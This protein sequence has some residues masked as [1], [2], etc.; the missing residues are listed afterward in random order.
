[1]PAD[2]VQWMVH[3]LRAER[4]YT[5]RVLAFDQ[6]GR[7]GPSK[8]E[9]VARGRTAEQA[10]VVAPEIIYVLVKEA[11]IDGYA[12]LLDWRAVALSNIGIGANVSQQK[13][14]TANGKVERESQRGYKVRKRL[15]INDSGKIKCEISETNFLKFICRKISEIFK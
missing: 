10:P 6:Y 13:Y 15:G 11:G 9:N 12:L 5:C 1:M 14:S 8:V 2:Y 3:S 4:E 7:M